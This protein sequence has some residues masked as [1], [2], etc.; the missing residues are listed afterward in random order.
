MVETSIVIYSDGH[1]DQMGMERWVTVKGG[2]TDVLG[3]YTSECH[4]TQHNS[5]MDWPWIWT[6]ATVV[7][8][9]ILN[10]SAMGYT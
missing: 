4:F 8:S 10:P 6:Q 2:K 1:R 7:N 5:H 3:K 9:Q